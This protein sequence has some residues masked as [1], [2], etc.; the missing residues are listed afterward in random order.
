MNSFTEARPLSNIYVC[1]CVWVSRR[2]SYTGVPG[3]KNHRR[4]LEL[5]KLFNLYMHV[6]SWSV[7]FSGD[8]AFKF[9]KKSNKKIFF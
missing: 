1:V 9:L 6:G 3:G 7:P 8:Y 4:H 2:M 5:I